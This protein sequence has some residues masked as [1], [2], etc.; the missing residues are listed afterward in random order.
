MCSKVVDPH[1]WQSV[2]RGSGPGPGA[3]TIHASCSVGRPTCSIYRHAVEG[4]DASA[5]GAFPVGAVV[6][7]TGISAAGKSTVAEL[8]ARRFPRG[9]HVRGDTFRRMVVAGREEMGPSASDEALHQLVLRYELGASV[10]DTYARAG[11]VVV[12]QDIIVGSLLTHVIDSI[13]ARPRFLVVLAPDPDAVR[14]REAQRAKVAYTATSHTIE[15]L[16]A[17]LRNETRRVGLWLDSTLLTPTETVTAI[18]QR[19]SEARLDD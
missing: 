4:N 9:V 7:I 17:A 10:A 8:L 18:E 2:E 19:A 3:S 1:T 14:E 11:F 16:D 13:D 15:D 6:V 12:L 5:D